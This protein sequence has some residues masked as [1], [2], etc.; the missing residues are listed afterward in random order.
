M[1]CL[2]G[3]ASRVRYKP[4]FC[5]VLSLKIGSKGSKMVQRRL[6]QNAFQEMRASWKSGTHR[7]A[8]GVSPAAQV[9][10]DPPISKRQISSPPLDIDWLSSCSWSDL[11]PRMMREE[12]STMD[13]LKRLDLLGPATFRE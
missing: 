10:Q 13:R 4:S 1:H 5:A 6:C 9:Q 12:S 3:L 2:Y 11:S 7:N 8:A